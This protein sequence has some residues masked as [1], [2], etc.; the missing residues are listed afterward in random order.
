M[1]TGLVCQFYNKP[2]HLALDCY[3]RMNLTYEGR[4]PTKHL[5]T[6]AT[7]PITMTRQNNGPWFFDTSANAHVTPKL[8]NLVNPK[9]FT[10]ND[11]VGG[12]G[13]DFGLSIS[14]LDQALL[15]LIL[16]PFI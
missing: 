8:Q 3:Q 15:T 4:I 10:G 7:S 11:N 13:N 1:N 5:T 9:D 14:H 16:I 12:V 6:M 2:G